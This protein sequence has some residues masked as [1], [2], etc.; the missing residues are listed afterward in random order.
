MEQKK[1]PDDFWTAPV[2]TDPLAQNPD[3]G[4]DLER[5]APHEAELDTIVQQMWRD[6]MNESKLLEDTELP[7][8]EEIVIPPI[9]EEEFRAFMLTFE[10]PEKVPSVE[11]NEH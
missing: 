4:A 9:T 10:Q 6:M 8:R 5:I 1:L 2:D 7:P 11:K 3:V